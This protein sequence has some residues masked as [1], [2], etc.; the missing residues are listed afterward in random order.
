MRQYEVKLQ[1][2]RPMERS[3]VQFGNPERPGLA[4]DLSQVKEIQATLYTVPKNKK[5]WT[6]LD[7]L[8]ENNDR[9]NSM[10]GITDL[11]QTSSRLQ[12]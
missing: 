12:A 3:F 11:S 5:P 4:D 8:K 7:M 9:I 6:G 1:P 2:I 10:K